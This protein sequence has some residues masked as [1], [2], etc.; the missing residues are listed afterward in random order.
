MKFK[1][2]NPKYKKIELLIDSGE[3]IPEYMVIKDYKFLKNKY[4]EHEVLS[5]MDFD[6]TKTTSVI[7]SKYRA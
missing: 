1:E 4:G 3:F 2:L 6:H 7:V 5:I